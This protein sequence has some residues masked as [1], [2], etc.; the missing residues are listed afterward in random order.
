MK[1]FYTKPFLT[2]QQRSNNLAKGHR[3]QTLN[4]I[5]SDLINH[6]IHI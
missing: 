1:S 3:K 2:K 4:I 5:V 6:G